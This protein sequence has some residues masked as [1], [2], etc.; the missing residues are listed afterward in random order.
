MKA[1]VWTSLNTAS[2]NNMAKCRPKCIFDGEIN[3]IPRVGEWVVVR[4][5]FCAE[6]VTNVT[7]DLINGDVEISVRTVDSTGEYGACLER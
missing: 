2:M 6:M 3:E 1:K 5:G 7:H 4:D